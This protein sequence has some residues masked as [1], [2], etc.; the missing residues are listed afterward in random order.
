[1]AQERDRCLRQCATLRKNGLEPNGPASKAELIRRAYYDITGLPPK[2]AE[3]KAFIADNSPDAFEKV[4]DKLLASDQY[5]ERWGRHWLDLVRFAETNGYERDSRKDL[6]W[7]YRDYIIRAFNQDKPYDRFIKEQ[8]AGDLL[9][10][11]DGDSVTATGFYRLGIWDDEPVDRELARYEY[12]DDILR[13][14]GETFLGM[15]L[16]RALPRS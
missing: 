7:K 6:I 1:M 11:R 15:T 4:I 12:L 13:T 5:G 10:D 9:P 16:L 2:I 3:V 8:L 14:M